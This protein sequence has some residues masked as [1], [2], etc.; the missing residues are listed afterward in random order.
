M[1]E[2][3]ILSKLILY[4]FII[5]LI[6]SITDIIWIVTLAYKETVEKNKP[7]NRRKFIKRLRYKEFNI[8]FS[9]SFFIW[10]LVISTLFI[11]GVDNLFDKFL[12]FI[13][14]WFEKYDKNKYPQKYI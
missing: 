7:F 9:I 8:R 2:G 1:L 12:S 10:P 13:A 5:G 14:K 11:V 3:V 4:Y 6:F